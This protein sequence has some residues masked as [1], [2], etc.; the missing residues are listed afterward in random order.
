VDTTSLVQYPDSISTWR[1]VNIGSTI[2]RQG[3][4]GQSVYN[5][6]WLSG[7]Y[8]II[9]KERPILIMSRSEED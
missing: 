4:S 6:A 5:P 2:Y 8:I 9:K 1:V 3:R 7:E